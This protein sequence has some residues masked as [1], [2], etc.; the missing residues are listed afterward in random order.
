MTIGG[1]SK[2]V[3]ISEYTLR[4]YEKKGLIKVKRDPVG[5]RCYE[6]SDIAWVAFI[7][8]LKSTGMLLKD[9]KK[10]ADLRY[11]GDG[12]MPERLSM[13]QTHRVYVLEQQA[14][15]AECLQNL[16]HKISYYKSAI[17]EKSKEIR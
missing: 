8:R 17:D 1:L 12:T 14:R 3:G 4:Y 13:L 7:Q 10:Y 5:R 15:W 11:E 9:I 6:E 16:D 2:A